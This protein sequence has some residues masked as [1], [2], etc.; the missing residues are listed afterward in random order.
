MQLDEVNA[1]SV[2]HMG[3]PHID[4]KYKRVRLTDEFQKSLGKFTFKSKVAL[5]R[6]IVEVLEKA[7]EGVN[8]EK[9]APKRPSVDVPPPVKSTKCCVIL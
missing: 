5:Q 2:K 7:D 4:E 9:F 1:D 3:R 8:F 6:E